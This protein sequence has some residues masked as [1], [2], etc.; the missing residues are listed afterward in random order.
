[1]H[2]NLPNC[3][4]SVVWYNKFQN[5]QREQSSGTTMCKKYLV[6]YAK[7]FLRILLRQNTAVLFAVCVLVYRRDVSNFPNYL[8]I[9]GMKTIYF[10]KAYHPGRPHWPL[11]PPD[12]SYHLTTWP[13]DPLKNLDKPWITWTTLTNRKTLT[14]LTDQEKCRIHIFTWSCLFQRY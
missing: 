5:R 1:M 6:L 3:T 8:I 7:T 9:L 10:L 12:H 13:P 4:G 14:T 2:N 11:L